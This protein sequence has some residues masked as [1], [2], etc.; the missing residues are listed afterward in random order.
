MLF[1][2]TSP[3]LKMKRTSILSITS[4]FLL[5]IAGASLGQSSPTAKVP[6]TPSITPQYSTQ[7]TAAPGSGPVSYASMTQL[8]GLLEALEATSKTTQGDLVRLRIEHWK[9][10]NASKR[11]ALSN[12]DSIQRNLQGALPAILAQLRTT[13][14]DVPATFKL[15]RNLDALYDVLGSVV[16]GTGAFGSKDDLQSL[17]NDLTSFEGTRK[18]IAERIESLAAGKEAEIVRLRADLKTAQA[19]IPATPPKITVVDDNPPAKKP[20][21]KK[22]APAKAPTTAPGAAP[23]TAKPAAGQTAAPATQ[24]PPAK[25]Q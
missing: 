22:K 15:Y 11:Q 25:P 21:V 3:L 7:G 10:D 6:A 9:T 19:A 17:S 4:S 24:A 12:V 14:E 1:S 20:A 2:T 13:P 16:E 5:L 18:Q 23:S 8:N